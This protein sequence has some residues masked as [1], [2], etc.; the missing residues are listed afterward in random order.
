MCFKRSVRFPWFQTLIIERGNSNLEPILLLNAKNGYVCLHPIWIGLIVSFFGYAGVSYA[1]SFD[2]SHALFDQLLK[3]Y[4]EPRDSKSY[5]KYEEL[6][7]NKVPL[8]NYV[9]AVG[10]IT[11]E[12][13]SKFSSKQQL[14][15]LINSYNAF[16]VKLIADHYPIQSIKDIPNA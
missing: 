15:F 3:K 5:V 12:E 11:Q 13:F 7:K 16:T 10:G 9:N 2:H 14:S 1:Q 4:V 8:D 6:V